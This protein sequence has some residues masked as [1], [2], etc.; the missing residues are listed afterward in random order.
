MRGFFGLLC[1]SWPCMSVIYVEVTAQSCVVRHNI[2]AACSLS[3]PSTLLTGTSELVNWVVAT[4]LEKRGD[5]PLTVNGS[6]IF[7]FI[8]IGTF[9]DC[10]FLVLGLTW[11]YDGVTYCFWEFIFPLVL[12]ISLIPQI[13]D[14]LLLKLLTFEIYEDFLF[15]LLAF[16]RMNAAYY[17]FLWC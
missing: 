11:G 9:P 13:A 3:D 7:Y 5:K 2:C 4:E 14:Y 10:L 12:I 16:C 17:A 8:T 15:M 1:C 6:S